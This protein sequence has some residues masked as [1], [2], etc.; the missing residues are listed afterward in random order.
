MAYISRFYV[1][2]GFWNSGI[3]GVKKVNIINNAPI[4]Q[5][6]ANESREFSQGKLLALKS[7]VSSRNAPADEKKKN[8]MLSQAGDS[9][10]APL[11]V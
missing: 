8:A 2:I 10:K 4:K 9:P 3:C 6:S 5:M 11:Y 7:L 1:Y